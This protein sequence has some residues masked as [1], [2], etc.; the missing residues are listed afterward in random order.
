MTK[1]SF[2][3]K[4]SWSLVLLTIRA[5]NVPYPIK[6][7]SSHYEI[8]RRWQLLLWYRLVFMNFWKFYQFLKQF[9]LTVSQNI[10]WNKLPF[11]F[12]HFMELGAILGVIWTLHLL[13]FLYSE[14]I[15]IPAYASPLSLI[16]I[17]T[18]FF[19]NPTRRLFFYPG[20]NN[21]CNNYGNFSYL[22]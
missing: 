12:Q 9:F 8:K 18:L 4:W 7:E 15:D 10:F 11:S 6:Q 20:K 13:L 19:I 17:M 5:Q 16:S 14:F 21:S 2:S 22:A 1:S 3:W